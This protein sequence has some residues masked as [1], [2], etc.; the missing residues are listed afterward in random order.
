MI[1]LFLSVHVTV[2]DSKR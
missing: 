1:I 2:V